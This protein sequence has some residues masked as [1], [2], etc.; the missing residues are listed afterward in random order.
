MRTRAW[1]LLMVLM[2]SGCSV[3]GIRSGTAE[4]SYSLVAKTGDLEIR[5]YAPRV[6]IETVIADDEV[7]ARYQGFRR[8][9]GY[10]FGANK[11]RAKIA[12]TAPV[13]QDSAGVPEK[14][15][16]TAPVAE[17]RDANGHWRIQFFAP[18]SYR[19]E[20]MPIPDDPS[21][22]I[23]AVPEATYAIHRFTGDRSPR[24]IA[25]ETRKLLAELQGSGWKAT[26]NP[27]AWFYDPPWTLPFCRRNEVGVPA[28]IATP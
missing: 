20:T 23:V 2:V 5:R 15:A 22:E 10:I 25:R 11:T 28:E 18:A 1:S 6:A 7:S 21:V 24:A 14:I 9:A 13:A 17:N 26:G 16:M 3:F 19:L 4:P 12:M 27:F 8:L